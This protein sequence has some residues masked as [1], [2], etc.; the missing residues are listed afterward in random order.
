[1]MATD[2]NNQHA[3]YQYAGYFAT[4]LTQYLCSRSN[5]WIQINLRHLFLYRT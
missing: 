2:G 3:G 4:G 1:M 5:Y